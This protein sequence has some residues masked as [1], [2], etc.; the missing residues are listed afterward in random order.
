MVVC[1]I[2]LIQ[3]VDSLSLHQTID[4]VAGERGI[5]Q[6]VLIQVNIGA[7]VAKF[8]LDVTGLDTLIEQALG[9]SHIRVRGLMTM[10]P[11]LDD[12]RALRGLF[13][14]MHEVFIDIRGKTYDN[15][16]MDYLSM[17]MSGDFVDAVLEGANMIRVGSTIFGDRE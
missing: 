2:F 9:L 11:L 6:D 15:V 13:A 10:P 14:Q 16:R 3:S 8:G 5:L 17:G 1:V 12:S 7:D 4:R